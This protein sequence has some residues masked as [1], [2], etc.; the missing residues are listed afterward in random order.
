MSYNRK[1][2]EKANKPFPK[3]KQLDCT[4]TIKLTR[5]QLKQLRKAA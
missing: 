4:K 5:K 2:W 3:R 1:Q